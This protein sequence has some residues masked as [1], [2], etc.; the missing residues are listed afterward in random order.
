M[1][2]LLFGL[3]LCFTLLIPHATAQEL[4]QEVCTLYILNVSSYPITGGAYIIPRLGTEGKIAPIAPQEH[5][6][7]SGPCFPG[8]MAVFLLSGDPRAQN[9]E[10]VFEFKDTDHFFIIILDVKAPTGAQT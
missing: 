9:K 4:P 2:R 1:K 6:D 3:A 7:M 10:H 5:L 8:P